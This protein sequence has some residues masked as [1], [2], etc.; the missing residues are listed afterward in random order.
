M[1]LFFMKPKHQCHL[2]QAYGTQTWKERRLLCE[3]VFVII[4]TQTL[5][6]KNGWKKCISYE[7]K[8]SM[9]FIT[10]SRKSLWC[11]IMK[12]KEIIMWTCVSLNRQ[13]NFNFK[14]VESEVSLMK[15]KHQYQLSQ[16][17]KCVYS[18]Q[19]WEE[20]RYYINPCLS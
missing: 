13:T 2:S 16:W 11:Q 10:M 12:R 7:T 17:A 15:P 3:F 14:N 20:R 1:K 5:I 19:S 4:H 9:S 6:L 8:A 18:A